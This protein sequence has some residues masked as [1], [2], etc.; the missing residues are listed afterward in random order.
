MDTGIA[1]KKTNRGALLNYVD[2][3]QN[4]DKKCR[5][6]TKKN[7]FKPNKKIRNPTDQSIYKREKDEYISTLVVVRKKFISWKQLFQIAEVGYNIDSVI[8][9]NLQSDRAI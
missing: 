1:T 3:K 2:K 6:E 9:T 7:Y 8:F 5:N 4:G